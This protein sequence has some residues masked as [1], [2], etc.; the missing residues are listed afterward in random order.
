MK[1]YIEY[2]RVIT[3]VYE[4]DANTVKE[5]EE[6]V[7]KNHNENAPNIVNRKTTES[8]RLVNG[9]YKDGKLREQFKG[10]YD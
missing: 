7:H 3:E 5:A 6:K 10:F 1:H 8:Y 4:V 2:K 9:M